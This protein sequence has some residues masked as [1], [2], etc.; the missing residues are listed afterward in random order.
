MLLGFLW[1]HAKNAPFVS[2]CISLIFNSQ[3]LSFLTF[4]NTCVLYVA[5]EGDTLAN[6][7]VRASA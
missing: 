4:E 2:Q 7:V 5:I 6:D 1:I 3:V